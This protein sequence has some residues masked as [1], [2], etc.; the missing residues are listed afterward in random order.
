[1]SIAFLEAE[2]LLRQKYNPERATVSTFLGK[3]LFGRTV[4]RILVESGQ[5]KRIGGWIRPERQWCHSEEGRMSDPASGE[6]SP[7]HGTELE[8]LLD[9]IHPDIRGVAE[10]LAEGMSVRDVVEEDSRS[11]LFDTRQME[12]NLD[13][14]EQELLA[15]LRSEV[16][17]VTE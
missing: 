6:A 2:R 1:V 15:I 7:E 13:L 4:Y 17:R 9:Q 10:R 16:R 14:A 11:P 12:G 5:R 8:D 3:W